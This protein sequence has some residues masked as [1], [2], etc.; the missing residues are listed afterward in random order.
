M[1]H[2]R[3]P[4]DPQDME[5]SLRRSFSKWIAKEDDCDTEPFNSIERAFEYCGA[6]AILEDG[7]PLYPGFSLV[8]TGAIKNFIR[9]I[10]EPFGA[11]ESPIE[12][13]LL[14]AMLV[15]AESRDYSTEL[16]FRDYSCFK[17]EPTS[18]D[19]LIIQGQ[20]ELGEYRVD[21][22]L[23]QESLM[24]DTNNPRTLPDG[25]E[26]PGD[27]EITKHLIV[28]CDGHDYH[29]RT[30]EQASRDRARDRALQSVGYP[31]YRY[32]GSDIWSDVFQCAAEAITHLNN[33]VYG[34]PKKR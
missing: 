1:A 15:V 27:R 10:E 21:F 2:T 11:C 26:V 28:E 20:K 32:T 24:P 12:R 18:L 30:K 7:S 22:L 34:L 4:H 17:S 31:V 23:S 9:G 16:R 3:P 5:R 6:N 8:V 14:S 29:E 25:Q 13:M 33:S 19:H